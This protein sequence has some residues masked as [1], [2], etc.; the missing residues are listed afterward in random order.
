M[1]VI[2]AEKEMK[3]LPFFV[4]WPFAVLLEEE[5]C[6]SGISVNIY[7]A[8]VRE[9]D[10]EC[11]LLRLDIYIYWYNPMQ[12]NGNNYYEENNELFLLLDLLLELATWSFLCMMK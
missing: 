11:N 2:W 7:N 4:K 6:L 3:D 10:N 8:L 5:I 1:F 12:K 9:E